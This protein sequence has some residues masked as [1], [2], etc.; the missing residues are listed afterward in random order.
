MSTILS[1]I[2][3]VGIIAGGFAVTGDLGRLAKRGY[4]VVNARDIPSPRAE[5]PLEREHD[6]SHVA[7]ASS[8]P[9]AADA[10]DLQPRAAWPT[11]AAAASAEPAASP[12]RGQAAPSKRADFRPPRDGVEQVSVATLDA[13][14]RVVV[15]LAMPR[16]SGGRAYRCLV[17]DV[18][19]PSTGDALAYEAVSFTADGTPQATAVPP[20]RV[21]LQGNGLGG[22]IVK[23][24]MI[25]VGRRG[26]AADGVGHETIGPIAALD[27]VR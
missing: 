24:G 25:D 1:R 26:V 5:Q 23:N 11:G 19:D 7:E 8:E 21:R 2:A 18:V 27:L 17:F 16:R 9:A 3:A 4:E 10:P 20:H 13:G 12:L 6:S 22:A 14:N 15:W